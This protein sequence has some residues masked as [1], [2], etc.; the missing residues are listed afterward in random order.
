MPLLLRIATYTY[1]ERVSVYSVV[2][3]EHDVQD[4]ISCFLGSLQSDFI[5]TECENF[6]NVTHLR[7]N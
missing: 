4:H 7:R 5:V 3:M 1:V 6:H 2:D